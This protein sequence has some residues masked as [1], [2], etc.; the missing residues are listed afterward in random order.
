MATIQKRKN[1]DGTT[2][3]LALVRIKPYKPASKA[4]SA[5]S[6]AEAWAE[7]LEKELRAQRRQ[8]AARRDFSRLTV[9]NLIDEYLADPETAGKRSLATKQDRLSWWVSNFG[10]EKISDLNVVTLREAR[11]K[12]QHGR[13][14]ATVNRYISEMRSCWNWG[15]SAGLVVENKTWP[16]RLMLSEPVGRTRHLSDEELKTL[17]KEGEKHSPLMY[18]AIVLS[19]GC[20]LRQGELLRLAWSDLDLEKQRL[21]VMIAKNKEARSVH[22]PSAA[23][24][25][26]K[27]LKKQP[28]VGTRVFVTENGE[29]LKKTTL[30]ARWRKVRDAAGLADFRWHDLR[31]SCASFLAQSGATLLEIG[32]VLGHKSPSVT[33]RYAHLVQGA[34]VKGHTELDQKLN[35]SPS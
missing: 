24:H 15:R 18:A 26:L 5:R 27:A 30:E 35:Q 33:Q 4:F 3:F 2:S 34:P 32:S 10:P 20:G 1:K 29:P 25:A 11:Q 7:R 9:K 28:I 19:V 17:L 13:G 31:H 22:L 16:M 21:R 12:L 14:H 8:G 23:V 6:D